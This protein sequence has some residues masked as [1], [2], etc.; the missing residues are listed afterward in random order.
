MKELTLKE[1]EGLWDSL[2]GAAVE[3]S[4]YETICA[5]LR[6][7]GHEE[8]QWDP[9]EE[10]S[11]AFE[12]F[13]G[14]FEQ[15][16]RERTEDCQLRIALLMYC[17][18]VE[19]SAVHELL[20]NLLRIVD[21][22]PYVMRPFAELGPKK[23]KQS[24]QTGNP[25]SAKVK[26]R[27]ITHLAKQAERTEVSKTIE[28]FFHDGVRN[29]FSHSDYILTDAEL[30]WAEGS[31]PHRILR[32]DLCVLINNCFCF[33]GAFLQAQPRWRYWLGQLNRYYKWPRYEVLELL[34]SEDIG[35]Y[36]FSVHFPTGSKATY[37]RRPYEGSK[38]INLMPRQDGTIDFFIGDRDATEPVWKID[39]QPVTSWDA[40]DNPRA[41]AGQK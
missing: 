3:K 8:P 40:L 21:G 17:Q 18:A 31:G 23:K 39:G 34:A 28:L 32:D 16:K 41:C 7:T 35:L 13:S 22:R 29:A 4:A 20:A 27:E 12:D 24:L 11:R 14:L 36:G 37:V 30:R 33:V 1:C 19:M 38:P 25:P 26:F 5:V 2:F 15:A 6:V 10:S 9:L